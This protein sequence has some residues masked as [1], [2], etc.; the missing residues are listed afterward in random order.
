M[1]GRHHPINRT[2][3][4]AMGPSW[5]K[6]TCQRNECTESNDACN[7][8]SH[9]SPNTTRG[10]ERESS[11]TSTWVHGK[12]SRVYGFGRSPSASHQALST[13]S[14]PAQRTARCAASSSCLVFARIAACFSSRAENRSLPREPG[15]SSCS[16]KAAISTTSCPSPSTREPCGSASVLSLTSITVSCYL[17]NMNSR[18]ITQNST[19]TMKLR[20]AY[21]ILFADFPRYRRT[22][23]LRFRS[24]LQKQQQG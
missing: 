24:P 17:P 14:L 7:F 19:A 20:A 8:A 13:A 6:E 1:P 5:L 4:D 2:T 3:A 9:A 11:R 23:P 10:R 16:A 18:A 15:S 12:S 21:V 22:Q